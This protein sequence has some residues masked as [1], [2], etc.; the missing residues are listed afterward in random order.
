[1]IM[2][3][4]SVLSLSSMLDRIDKTRSMFEHVKENGTLK[5]ATEQNGYWYEIDLET[6]NSHSD[7]IGW[8]LHL[9]EK[10]W[11][12]VHMARTFILVV[13]EIKGWNFY[14]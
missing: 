4:E 9:L 3:D 10:A 5:I 13:A 14:K 12:D 1:M 8:T 7:L 11:F 2:C 6:I